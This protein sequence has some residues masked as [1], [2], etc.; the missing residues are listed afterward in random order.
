M[1]RRIIISLFMVMAIF[2][3]ATAEAEIT[4]VG[5]NNP[6]VDIQAIQKAVDQG[7]TIL[8]KGTFDFGDKG[9]VNIT[10]DVK[11]IGETDDQGT[12]ITKIKGGFWTFH[13]P[14]PSQLP[15]E[16]QGPKI[17]IQKIHF[18]GALWSAIHIAYCSA[19]TITNNKLTNIKPIPSPIPVFGQTGKYLQMAI[20]GGTRMA[21]LKEPRIFQPGAV[22]GNLFIADNHIDMYNEDPVNTMSQGMF[23]V[24]ASFATAQ[25]SGN[26]INHCS[27]NSIEI[28]DNFLDKDGNG[29]I[30]IKDN[31]IV[32]SQMGIPLPSPQ[33]PNGIIAGW[34]FD[35]PGAMDPKRNPKYIVINNGIRTRGQTSIGIFGGSD[36][37][38]ISNNAVLAEGSEGMGIGHTASNCYVAN[39]R[40]EGRGAHAIRIGPM[41]GQLG[42]K[43]F[44]IGNDFS[45]FKA[46]RCDVALEKDSKNN[47]VCGSSGTVVDQGAGNQIEGLKSVAK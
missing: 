32:T 26:T 23:I 14:L 16:V 20:I 17:T 1:E 15:V 35:P 29:T 44:L 8:L 33:T 41:R 38:V 19:T 34:F 6:V 7:G 21:Q 37:A 5:Q 46:S 2:S 24:W 3:L 22:V 45:Q 36:N 30:V 31:K 43:N 25:I 42:S 9:R 28:L 47:V 13:S 39:N 12:P 27:R 4:I 18:D 40:I 10:K 11:I